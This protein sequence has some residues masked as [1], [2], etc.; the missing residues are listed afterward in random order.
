MFIKWWLVQ[1]YNYYSEFFILLIT[2]CYWLKTN[3][4]SLCIDS[5]ILLN[6][7]LFQVNG[8]DDRVNAKIKLFVSAIFQPFKSKFLSLL[9]KK[10]RKIF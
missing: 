3:V 6:L 7:Q 10:Q 8:F 4:Q 9:L 1:Y 2:Q 5:Y